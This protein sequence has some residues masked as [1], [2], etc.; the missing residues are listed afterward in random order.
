MNSHSHSQLYSGSLS[1]HFKRGM[2]QDRKGD[3]VSEGVKHCRAL[4]YYIFQA[5]IALSHVTATPNLERQNLWKQFCNYSAAL[6]RIHSRG[7][8]WRG[9]KA[10]RSVPVC[11]CSTTSK[12]SL[13]AK[14]WEEFT[15][16]FLPHSNA[17]HTHCARKSPLPRPSTLPTQCVFRT[18]PYICLQSTVHQ[19]AFYSCFLSPLGTRWLMRF[20]PCTV[21]P[22]RWQCCSGSRWYLVC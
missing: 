5:N 4:Y 16:F 22:A 13:W 9:S 7:R 20:L 3:E 10:P 8:L 6:V 1:I 19:G 17:P 12:Q 21:Q 18:E 2:T 11:T 15:F 14:V